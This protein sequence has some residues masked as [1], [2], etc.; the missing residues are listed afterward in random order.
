MLYVRPI[1]PSVGA[2][3]LRQGR[4]TW[5]GHGAADLGLSG[6][7]D[8]SDLRA[9]LLGRDPAS[10]RFLP[11]VRPPR[12]RAGWD[13]VF[14]A[15]KSLSLV[16]ASHASAIAERVSAAQR[17]AVA[18]ALS[19]FEQSHLHVR[20]GGGRA[21]AS[22]A[23]AAEFDHLAN[24]GG[25]P[26][27]HTHV[28]LLNLARDR[29][30]RWSSIGGWWLERRELG[31]IYAM[32][33]RHHLV[34][35][36]IDVEWRVRPDGLMDVAGVPRAA[37]RAVSTRTRDAAE[38]NRYAGRLSDPSRPWRQ[39]ATAAGW[40]AAAGG[41]PGATGTVRGADLRAA[42]TTRLALKGSAFGRRDVLLALASCPDAR[43]TSEG[44]R[45]WVDG[46]LSQCRKIDAARGASTTGGRADLWTSELAH[47][48]DRRLEELVRGRL[49]RQQRS[50]RP[51]P[52]VRDDARG[53]A[54]RV[55]GG[56]Q[57]AVLAGEA[58]KSRFLSH[59]AVAAA[60]AELCAAEG[61]TVAVSARST[62]DAFRWTTLTGIG[63]FQASHAVDLLLVD[64]ADRRPPA[65]LA[66]ILGSAGTARVVLV[67][68]GTSLRLARPASTFLAEPPDGLHR[69]DAGG[70]AMTWDVE[71]D[72]H[73]HPAAAMLRRWADTL[74]ASRPAPTMLVAL[75]VPEIRALNDAARRHLT[76]LGRLTG[77]E[78]VVRGRGFRRG[79]TVVA[80]RPLGRGLPAGTL[81]SVLDV[82]LES[83]TALIRWPRSDLTAERA[84]L[85]RIGHGYAATPLLASRCDLPALVLG[86]EQ[87]LGL[88]RSRVLEAFSAREAG[89]PARAL[90]ARGV[91]GPETWPV[92]R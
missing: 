47:A 30:G 61:M 14:A 43:F 31:A 91:Y 44:A 21:S 39:R 75:G 1:G 10:G 90:E 13:L 24:A 81:G 35:A 45:L 23:I 25:E 7:V 92:Q 4:G 3:Y 65:E 11:L 22:G 72:Q 74:T 2:Y 9:A 85:A 71:G 29:E 49:G 40:D 51:T 89:G 42:V 59:A 34:D 5:A 60:S 84:A 87:G 26:H 55:L 57:V 6:D 17:A 27:L 56:D 37:L 36:G 62:L 80:V 33:L 38:G 12:R 77:P 28:L 48:T 67:E 63:S 15:P 46:F 54:E 16:A 41:A 83:S 76:R 52:P 19:H 86:P 70:R 53:C 58:G 69:I 88:E 50:H 79:D 73:A 66:V 82:N 20:R 64:Q 78:L 8:R 68:G 32:G 18:E